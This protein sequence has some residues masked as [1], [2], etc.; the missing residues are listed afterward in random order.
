MKRD[1]KNITCITSFEDI[2]LA[3]IKP[4]C[5]SIGFLFFNCFL[6]RFQKEKKSPSLCL[7]CTPP[8]SQDGC[9]ALLLYLVER[10]HCSKLNLPVTIDVRTVYLYKTAAV[11]WEVRSTELC[12]LYL[13]R[14]TCVLVRTD[15]YIYK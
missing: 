3:V 14:C 7:E 6:K 5:L 2:Q 15:M 13:A 12:P 1:I 8:L 11:Q 4:L 9:P 10:T